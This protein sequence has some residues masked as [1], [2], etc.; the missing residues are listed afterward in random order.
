MRHRHNT[1]SV[2]V[3]S[4]SVMP[5][6]LITIMAAMHGCFLGLEQYKIQSSADAAALSVASDLSQIMMPDPHYGMVALTD[7][8]SAGNSNK[9][10]DG[11][12]LP[13]L[14][15]NTI[16]ATARLDLIIANQSG[17]QSLIKPAQAECAYAMACASRLSAFLQ[18]ALENGVP[19]ESTCNGV[20]LNL[21]E[22]AQIVLT[23]NLGQNTSGCLVLKLGVISSG[24]V[25]NIPLPQP[26]ELAQVTQDEQSQQK[27]K[28]FINEPAFGQ[29]FY[30]AGVGPQAGL[31]SFSNFQA[32]TGNQISS[33]VGVTLKT[34][35]PVGLFPG[36]QTMLQ[37][38]A[39]ARPWSRVDIPPVSM[40][41]TLVSSGGNPGGSALI[42]LLNKCNGSGT[43]GRSVNGDYGV[44]T[45]AVLTPEGSCTTQAF[46]SQAVIDWLRSER[47]QP[48]IVSACNFL[49]MRLS[50][51]N[52]ISIA[53]FS[54]T[55]SIVQ[56]QPE[57]SPFAEQ[58]V[59]DQQTYFS[60]DDAF[61]SASGQSIVCHDQVANYGVSGGKH[62]GQP[63]DG[64]PTNWADLP[65]FNG[66][67]SLGNLL[68]TG[69]S[70]V[71]YQITGSNTDCFTPGGNFIAAAVSDASAVFVKNGAVL[72][73]QPRKSS[74]SGGEAVF[75]QLSQNSL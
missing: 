5:L 56:I 67:L 34:P 20:A 29:D 73:Q 70:G 47:L 14:G 68:G 40:L 3:L 39:A 43:N 66:G 25:S 64:D 65:N 55:G 72:P 24:D 28:A 7:Y 63:I 60:T 37:A 15:I 4:T 33:I 11:Q 8:P 69:Q 1:G 48:N 21:K 45:G 53:A 16:L 26:P 57:Q 2:I 52:T 22:D 36:F 51:D 46:L 62:E 74:Y 31:C 18:T 6:I 49:K 41:V 10:P 59:S 17:A 13:V 42:D 54:K 9:A 32:A 44:D 19:A 12:A 23:R 61:G 71:T 58:S 75:I 30:F 35:K 50:A 38:N 27:Y